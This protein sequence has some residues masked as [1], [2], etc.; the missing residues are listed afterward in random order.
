[1]LASIP[2]ALLLEWSISRTPV[3]REE[4]VLDNGFMR[5]PS[6]PGHGMEFSEK[7]LSDFVVR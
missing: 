4:P 7:A 3:W 1:M 6:R 2:N 5:V